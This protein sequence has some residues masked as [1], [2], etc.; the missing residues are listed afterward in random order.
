MSDFRSYRTDR[1]PPVVK[2]LIIINVLVFIAQQILQDQLA[3][4]SKIMLYPEM[5][6]QLWDIL[7]R[8]AGLS[9][10]RKFRF[11]QIITHLFAHSGLFHI[12]FNMY[13]LWMFGSQLENLWGGKRFLSFYLLCGVGAAALHLGVQYFRSEQILQYLVQNHQASLATVSDN[14]PIVS[15]LAAAIAPA[16]GASGAVMGIF[17]AF[18]YLFPNTEMMIIPIPIPIKVKWLMLGLAAFDLFGGIAGGDNIAHFAHLGGALTGFVMVW[19]WSRDR[20]S[21]Y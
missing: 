16:L 15:S 17:A 5:P 4:T 13:S 8:D 2:N 3:L 11:Y 14:D 10:D 1:F 21:F 9:P 19:I 18:A 20:R 7:V 12:L 6:Q